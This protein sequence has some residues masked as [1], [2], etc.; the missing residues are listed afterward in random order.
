MINKAV[1]L[2]ALFLLVG[3]DHSDNYQ[4]TDVWHPTGANAANL[5]ATLVDQH[6]LIRGKGVAGSD[7][8]QAISAIEKL[9]KTGSKALP[10][11]DTSVGSPMATSSPVSS[12]GS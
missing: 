5:A 7:A 10:K 4:R 12:G 9:R 3:C 6:D 1:W 2:S 11:V 8:G